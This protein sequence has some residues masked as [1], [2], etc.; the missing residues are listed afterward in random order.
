ML[1]EDV[2]MHEQAQKSLRRKLHTANH[3]WKTREKQSIISHNVAM[4]KLRS[5]KEQELASIYNNFEAESEFK[6]CAVSTFGFPL[7]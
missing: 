3:Q 6:K 5:N 4:Q 7:R 2:E 1:R